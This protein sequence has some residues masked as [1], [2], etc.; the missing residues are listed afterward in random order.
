MKKI[1]LMLII[2]FSVTAMFAQG[3]FQKGNKKG[4]GRNNSMR[5]HRRQMAGREILDQLNLS[6]DQQ[7][8]IDKI[9]D[10]HQKKIID[11]RAKLAK[12]RID[13]RNAMK[14]SDFNLAEKI[15][16]KISGQR[17]IIAKDRIKLQ[18]QIFNTLTKEQQTKFEELRKEHQ[19]MRFDRF[20][21]QRRPMRN[22]PPLPEND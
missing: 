10:Q 15:T 4:F 5:Q 1:S 9:R 19:P 14:N 18:E 12:L 2:A 3:M 21:E 17:A 20:D 16:D 8:N 11:V 22:R 7:E 13:K 6:A